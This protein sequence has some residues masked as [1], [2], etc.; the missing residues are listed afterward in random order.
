M[1]CNDVQGLMTE[2]KFLYKSENQRL[3]IDSSKTS[4]KAVLLSNGN[5]LPSIPVVY[6][7]SLKKPTKIFKHY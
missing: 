7:V 1:H 2:L 5:E 3:F 6:G 4:L